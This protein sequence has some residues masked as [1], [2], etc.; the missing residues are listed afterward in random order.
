[1]EI[2]QIKHVDI[3]IERKVFRSKT[4]LALTSFPEFEQSFEGVIF[5]EKINC[6]SFDRRHQTRDLNVVSHDLNAIFKR[7]T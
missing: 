6:F 7:V 4:S 1:M 5:R 2:D 3:P